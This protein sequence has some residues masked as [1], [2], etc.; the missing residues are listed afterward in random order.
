MLE[1]RQKGRSH[2]VTVDEDKAYDTEDFV[3]TARELNVTVHVQKNEKGA[4]P[5]STGERRGTRGMP[6]RSAVA[7]SWRRPSAG[8]RGPDRCNK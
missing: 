3:A 5:A 6:A 1:Q 7:G 4:A 8:S 2:R